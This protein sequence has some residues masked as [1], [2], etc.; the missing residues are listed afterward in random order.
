MGNSIGKHVRRLGFLITV[1]AITLTGG[2][3]RATLGDPNLVAGSWAG[4]SYDITYDIPGDLTITL[5]P[6]LLNTFTGT[7]RAVYPPELSPSETCTLVGTIS[8]SRTL[9][10]TGVCVADGLLVAIPAVV[11]AKLDDTGTV[12]TG[13]FTGILDTGTFTLHKQ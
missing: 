2:A 6:G 10:I 3:A 9:V 13:T 1:I 7:M 8:P 12:I 4:P 5:T 11:N